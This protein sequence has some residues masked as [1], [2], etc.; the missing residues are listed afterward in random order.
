M[1]WLNIKKHNRV[2]YNKLFLG[3]VKFDLWHKINILYCDYFPSYYFVTKTLYAKIMDSAMCSL[4]L[5]E[6]WVWYSH[7]HAHLI[8]NHIFADYLICWAFKKWYL[9]ST[10]FSLHTLLS[11]CLCDDSMMLPKQLTCVSEFEEV[12]KL[13]KSQGSWR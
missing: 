8:S 9:F 4:F 11:S 12:L 6:I 13:S 5:V 2:E 1:R 3:L 7:Y 10:W